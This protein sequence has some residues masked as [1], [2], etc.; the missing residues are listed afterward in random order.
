MKCSSRVGIF[1]KERVDRAGYRMQSSRSIAIGNH[2]PARAGENF[3]V[4]IH[5]TRGDFGTANIHANK[6]VFC[7]VRGGHI[8]VR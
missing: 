8:F 6:T 3:A 7:G 2:W 1:R 5:E 4:R